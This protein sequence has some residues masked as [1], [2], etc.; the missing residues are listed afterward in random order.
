MPKGSY[1]DGKREG[2][3]EIYYVSGNLESKGSY[4]DGQKEGPWEYYYRDGS[5]REYRPGWDD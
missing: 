2:P 5:S 3:W 4:K 1:K